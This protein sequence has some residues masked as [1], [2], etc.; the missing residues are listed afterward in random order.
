MADCPHCGNSLFF[1]GTDRSN[2][3]IKVLMECMNEEEGRPPG[4]DK[5][6]YAE[7]DLKNLKQMEV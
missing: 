7:V 1:S 5:L 4:C 3:E 6:F 2:E